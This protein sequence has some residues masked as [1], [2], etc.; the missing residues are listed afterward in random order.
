MNTKMWGLIGMLNK[1]TFY[2][3]LHIA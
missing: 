3:L 2:R 1:T